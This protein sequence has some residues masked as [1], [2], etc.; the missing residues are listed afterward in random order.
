MENQKKESIIKLNYR[1]FM[2]NMESDEIS[3]SMKGD[4]E[5][6][7]GHAEI[8]LDEKGKDEVRDIAFRSAE[9]GEEAGFI[10]GF[11]Y[12]FQLFLECLS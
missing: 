5:K 1:G 9:A 8:K 2:Q 3:Q 6:I 7:L 11:R 4:I 10:R 12:A